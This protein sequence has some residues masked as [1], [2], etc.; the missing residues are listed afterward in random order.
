MNN[1]VVK[2]LHVSVDGKKILNGVNIEALSGKITVLMGPNGS[3]KST[4]AQVIM[5]HPR[6]TVEKGSVLF[7]N[8][9]VFNLKVHERAKAGLF[10]S[11]QYPS[12]VSGVSVANFLRTALNAVQNK[13]LSVS[14]FR[15]LLH[16]KMKWLHI[17]ESFV[18]RSLNEG[19]SGGEKKKCEIL[20]LALLQ[21]KLAILDETDSGLDIDALKIVAEGINK[22][23]EQHP[24][25]GVL[26]ITH[27]NRILQYIKP[28]AVHVM[29]HGKIVMSGNNE[30]VKQLEEKGYDWVR[31]QTDEKVRLKMISDDR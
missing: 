27:Y 10:L 25:M 23:K 3:G 19:F 12:E 1:L 20:Q 24:E 21:P 18:N 30:L 2:D 29:I 6:Y 8:Q 28:D 15:T 11:F 14:E 26:L 17:D 13:H 4:L 5:G 9:D 31:K 16:E 7:N 22:V